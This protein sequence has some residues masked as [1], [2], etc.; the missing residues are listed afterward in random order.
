MNFDLYCA[1]SFDKLHTADSDLKGGHIIPQ[2]LRHV[3][4]EL[5]SSKVTLIDDQ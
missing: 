1:L 5:G 4:E 3:N 2:L